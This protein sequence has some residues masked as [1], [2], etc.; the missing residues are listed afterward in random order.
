MAVVLVIFAPMLAMVAFRG[1]QLIRLSEDAANERTRRQLD[2]VVAKMAVLTEQERSLLKTLSFVPEIAGA[3]VRAGKTSPLVSP[4]LAKILSASAINTTILIADKDGKLLGSGNSKADFG[5]GDRQYFRHAIDRRRFSVGGFMVSRSMAVPAMAFAYP[6]VD[7]R[8]N[9]DQVLIASVRLDSLEDILQPIGTGAGVGI[10]VFDLE[11]KR[12]FREPADQAHPL[13]VV[14]SAALRALAVSSEEEASAR[15]TDGGEVRRISRS[16]SLG[17]G[18][19]PYAFVA[20]EVDAS[21]AARDAARRLAFDL[22]FTVAAGLAA[23]IAAEVFGN[24]SIASRI[25]RLAAASRRYRDGDLSGR[26]VLGGPTDEI[27]ELADSFNEMVDSI[28]ERDEEMR[29]RNDSLRI[30]LAERESLL[31][32]VHHRVKNNLQILASIIDLRANSFAEAG[33]GRQII[34]LED[35][36][37]AMALLH[38][39]LFGDSGFNPEVDFASYLESLVANLLESYPEVAA[40]VDVEFSVSEVRLRLDDAL[41]L[42]LLAAEIISNSLKWAYP[43]GNYGRIRIALEADAEVYVLKLEDDGVGMPPGLDPDT[44]L[45]T[46]LQVVR[47]LAQQLHG[48]YSFSRILPSGTAFALS[49]PAAPTPVSSATQQS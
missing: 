10:E 4:L 48:S 8:G 40:W 41:P 29:I 17:D 45:S 46:G 34:E 49:I 43:S 18:S 47:A 30:A 16:L 2:T 3:A 15:G 6:V 20:A 32:Q 44:T 25:S 21:V 7:Q 42:G 12:L 23:A 38:D 27:S 24:L 37:Q 11:G 39:H 13:G 22:A 36:I 19:S 28:R 33:A 9:I 26:V 35:R 1:V 5:V 14:V 31:M